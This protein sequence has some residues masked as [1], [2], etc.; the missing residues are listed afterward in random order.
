MKDDK[1]PN[2]D[3]L[4]IFARFYQGKGYVYIKPRICLLTSLGATIVLISFHYSEFK[5]NEEDFKYR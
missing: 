2:K 5:I 4:H 3:D 1:F